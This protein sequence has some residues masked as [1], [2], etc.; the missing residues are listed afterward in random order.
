MLREW[1]NA[2]DTTVSSQRGASAVAHLQ[3]GH[4]AVALLGHADSVMLCASEKVEPA[5]QGL[6]NPIKFDVT[7]LS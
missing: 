5:Q 4:T 2:N 7:P 6:H 3:L 1:D